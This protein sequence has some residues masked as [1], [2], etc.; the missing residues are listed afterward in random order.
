MHLALAGTIQFGTSIQSAKAQ[1]AGDFPSLTVPQSKP[2]SPG[3]VCLAHTLSSQ[4]TQQPVSDD[5]GTRSASSE[6]QP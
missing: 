5:P 3:A 4:L 1:L 2:L 6:L